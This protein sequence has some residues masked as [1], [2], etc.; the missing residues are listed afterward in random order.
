MYFCARRFLTRLSDRCYT[1]NNGLTYCW[2]STKDLCNDGN[3]QRRPWAHLVFVAV[4]AVILKSFLC[5]STPSWWK[6]RRSSW[7]LKKQL[8]VS[9]L[10][11]PSPNW[12]EPVL[13]PVFGTLNC[14]SMI[15]TYNPAPFVCYVQESKMF[16]NGNINLIDLELQRK[17]LKIHLQHFSCFSFF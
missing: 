11:F 15:K 14:P 10:I 12:F 17:K 9:R 3:R 16:P 6:K 7:F 8:T 4:A 2:C 1:A 5:D 13:G